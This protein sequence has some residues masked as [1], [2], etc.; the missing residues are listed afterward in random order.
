MTS[1][2]AS[3]LLDGSSSD[4]GSSVGGGA[5]DRPRTQDMQKAQLTRRILMEA[6]GQTYLQDMVMHFTAEILFYLKP[7]VTCI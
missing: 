2:H 3:T 7:N 6:L 4:G 5:L 1:N